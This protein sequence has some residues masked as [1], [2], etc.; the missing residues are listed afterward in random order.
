MIQTK[1]LFQDYA[2]CKSVLDLTFKWV[3]E[4]EGAGLIEL[5]ELSECKDPVDWYI[6]DLMKTSKY[7]IF[8]FVAIRVNTFT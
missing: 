2:T 3:G 1:T 7:L 8:P 6:V 4:G 5:E